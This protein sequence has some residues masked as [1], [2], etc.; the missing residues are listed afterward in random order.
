MKRLAPWRI[1]ALQPADAL[2]HLRVTSA[3]AFAFDD[4]EL[5]RVVVEVAERVGNPTIRIDRE[6][7]PWARA[8]WIKTGAW[9]RIER[10]T[11]LPRDATPLLRT[12]LFWLARM[13]PRLL[14]RHHQEQLPEN[15][16]ASLTHDSKAGFRTT[17]QAMAIA[18]LNKSPA[19]HA[20]DARVAEMLVSMRPNP[21]PSMQAALRTAIVLGQ[22]AQLPAV[23]LW[24]T[25]RSRGT[26]DRIRTPTFAA[27]ELSAIAAIMPSARQSLTNALKANQPTRIA[28]EVTVR[29]AIRAIEELTAETND[30]T[31]RQLSPYRSDLASIFAQRSEDWVVPFGYAAARHSPT[32]SPSM[33][34]RLRQMIGSNVPTPADM[35]HAVRLADEAGDLAGFGRQLLGENVNLALT[36]DLAILSECQEAWSDAIQTIIHETRPEM[37][38]ASVESEADSP[39]PPAPVRHPDDLQKDRW[40]GVPERDGRAASLVLESVESNIF[41][42]SVEVRS[43]DGSELR[44]PVIFHLHDSYPKSVQHIK[45]IHEGKAVLTDWNAYGVFAIGVQV[46][47]GSGQWT[48]LEVDLKDLPELPKRFLAR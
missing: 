2:H 23:R 3:G 34:K 37:T 6:L 18:R 30:P 43:T 8:L 40:G 25:S 13:A 28:D 9:Q 31:T 5:D 20:L 26:Y 48:S 38:S 42:F 1:A 45:R 12:H 21:L 4:T 46:K 19:F 32:L 41:Y 15:E 17:V 22:N 35:L 24:L 27:A 11:P 39:P 16:L 47:T 44:P 10:A 29:T 7:Q 14:N 33:T 36:P